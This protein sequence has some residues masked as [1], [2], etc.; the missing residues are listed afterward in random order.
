MK[1]EDLK[2]KLLQTFILGYEGETPPEKIYQLLKENLGGIIFFAQNLKSRSDFKKITAQ[3][4]SLSK[5]PPFLSI[6]QEGG[7]VERTIFLDK[8]V[9]YISPMSLSRLTDKNNL[10]KHYEILAEDLADL[11]INFNFAPVLDVNT[12][13]NNPIIGI[14][15][16]GDNP[17]TVS[18]CAKVVIDTF[19]ENGIINCGKHFAGHGDTDVDSHLN[20][21]CLNM[22]F[23]SFY[24]KHLISFEKAIAHGLDSIMVSHVNF[25]FFNE[26]KTPCSLSKNAV[27]IFLKKILKFKGLILTDDMVMGGITKH[28]GLKESIILALK[29]GV[30][31]M[32]FKNLTDELL[33][34]INEI[35]Q[36]A[37]SDTELKNKII[38]AHNK[39]LEFKKNYKVLKRVQNDSFFDIEERQKTIDKI[40]E[41]CIK[42]HK[43]LSAPLKNI[44]VI[45]YDTSKIYNL[46][47]NSC[48]LAELL[49]AKEITY[50][51]NPDKAEITK[52][53]QQIS[54]DT[55]IFISY[56]AQ[57]NKGQIELFKKIKNDK[58][59]ISTGLE[60]DITLFGVANSIISL[61]CP[62]PSMQ[63]AL[64]KILTKN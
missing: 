55:V 7:L 40:S 28:Y 18:D 4:K 1:K 52:I 61:S 5:T 22:D 54:Q 43:P 57:I 56:N 60:D 9:E 46:S 32:I 24:K 62:K 30:H 14:R 8:K 6:D 29:A 25:P 2:Q 50:S 51:L 10:K 44:V 48:N 12:N 27:E 35:A 58:I 15:A 20:M 19:K 11:G 37:F 38:D 64:A 59:L 31:C 21:P 63:K 13:P 3:M 16:F 33:K 39:I 36:D 41:N 26:V 49:S 45:S 47:A 53:V 34:A 23:D 17:D 42:I